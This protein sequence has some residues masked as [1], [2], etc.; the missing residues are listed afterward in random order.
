MRS[1]LIPVKD[2]ST[3][4][5]RLAPLL[6]QAQRTELAWAMLEGTFDAVSRVS[7]VDRIAVVTSY[8]PAIALANSLQLRS[9]CGNRTDLRIGV[10]R[11]C[12]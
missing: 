8:A 4:K 1:I 7:S 2:L 10:S 12:Q 6:T 9:N 3:A 5:Q 11:L